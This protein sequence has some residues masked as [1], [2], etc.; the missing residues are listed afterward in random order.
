MYMIAIRSVTYAN[1]GKKILNQAGIWCSLKRTP[2]EISIRGC[3]Y[4]LVLDDADLLE[5]RELFKKNG[6]PFEGIWRKGL[7]GKYQIANS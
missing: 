4:G 5:A 1:K 2:S 6:I 7:D 3:G